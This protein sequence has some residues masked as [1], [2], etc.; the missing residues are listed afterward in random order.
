MQNTVFFYFLTEDV[1]I[2]LP[3]FLRK[4]HADFNYRIVLRKKT[5]I[6]ALVII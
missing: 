4:R 3:C 5:A 6:E 2:I 1:C